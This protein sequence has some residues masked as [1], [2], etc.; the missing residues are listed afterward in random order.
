MS[1]DIGERRGEDVAAVEAAPR[2]STY[3]T[4]VVNQG[5]ADPSRAD[6]CKW[7]SVKNDEPVGYAIYDDNILA[8][9]LDI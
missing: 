4:Y 8:H 1:A 2:K 7:S 3:N 6:K 9:E 5:S